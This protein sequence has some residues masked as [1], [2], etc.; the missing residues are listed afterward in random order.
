[1]D[2]V[3]FYFGIF[4]VA[5]SFGI[6]TFSTISEKW[7]TGFSSEIGTKLRDWA[8]GQAGAGCYSWAA[9]SSND[10]N[11]RYLQKVH[12]L[13]YFRHIRAGVGLY[14]FRNSNP[15]TTKWVE[16]QPLHSNQEHEGETKRPSWRAESNV[17]IAPAFS[18]LRHSRKRE[19]FA[20]TLDQ[21]RGRGV[22]RLVKRE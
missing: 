8:V 10:S 2:Y 21:R 4:R 14:L 16:F 19:R 17:R 13:S 15:T 12:R 9:V 22:P 18:F 5:N 11:T 1:M 6:L 7:C 20:K 3:N